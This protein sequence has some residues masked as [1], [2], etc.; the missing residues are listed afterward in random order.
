MF[1]AYA[2]TPVFD[3]DEDRNGL[4]NAAEVR[5]LQ[6]I[7]TTPTPFVLMATLNVDPH[8]GEGH[9]EPIK[10]LLANPR[11]HQ[12]TPTTPTA[13]WPKYNLPPMRVDYILP[14]CDFEIIDHGQ[15]EMPDAAH[16]L[17]WLD[18]QRGVC[19]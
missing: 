4:R 3:G 19:Q 12:G 7:L 15:V 10:T 5:D 1:S 6:N 2:T 8:F 18:I 14:S 16:K 11:I 17:I 9:P 13:H